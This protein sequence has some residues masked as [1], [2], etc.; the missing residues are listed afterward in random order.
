MKYVRRGGRY[1]LVIIGGPQIIDVMVMV[2]QWPKGISGVRGPGQGLGSS[3]RVD[4][5]SDV[6][7]RVTEFFIPACPSAGFTL[8]SLPSLSSSRDLSQVQWAPHLG[9]NLPLEPSNLSRQICPN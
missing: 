6:V 3:V 7:D 4:I 9:R 2:W 5:A 1:P 8:G